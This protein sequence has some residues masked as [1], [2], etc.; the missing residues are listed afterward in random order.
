MLFWDDPLGA[1]NNEY[2]LAVVNQNNDIV[3]Y[4]NT[5]ID[6]NQDPYQ[7]LRISR[8]DRIVILRAPGAQTR[9]LHL[10]T[11]RAQLSI[12][13][14]GATLGHNASSSPNAFTVAAIRAS[15]RRAPFAG[16]ND[17]Q[18]EVYS[19]DGPRRVFYTPDGAELTPG[20]LSA[21][22]GSLAQKPDFTAAD[23]VTTDNPT[24][25]L[26]HFCGTSAAAPHAAAI[27]ALIKAANPALTP[28]QI[29]K[30]LSHT[31]LNIEAPGWNGAAGTGIV[32]PGPAL[33]AASDAAGQHPEDRA[34]SAVRVI[35][36]TDKTGK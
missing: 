15:G 2:Q 30:V 22:G 32:M 17:E 7:T 35:N 29:R 33:Q 3:S 11:N 27:A 31:S 25:G 14:S 28:A 16:G 19:S 36:T 21:T 24:Q 8:G 20:N 9:F 26:D 34:T 6:G 10:A 5:V 4:S 13:T 12:G 1:A 18:V 23:C